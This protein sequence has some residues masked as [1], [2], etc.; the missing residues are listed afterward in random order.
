VKDRQALL[1]EQHVPAK[2][3]KLLDQVKCCIREKHYS[4]RTEEAYVYR[5][6]WFRHQ[7][8][9]RFFCQAEPGLPTPAAGTNIAIGEQPGWEIRSGKE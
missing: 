2:P 5:I 4:L 3:P 9:S 8:Q 1:P 6:R 7:D